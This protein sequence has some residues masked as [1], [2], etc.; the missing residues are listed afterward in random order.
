MWTSGLANLA[1]ILKF[2]PRLIRW[3]ELITVLRGKFVSTCELETEFYIDVPNGPRQKLWSRE[4]VTLIIWG[5]VQ[6]SKVKTGEE[7]SVDRFFE[8]NWNGPHLI[9]GFT[10]ACVWPSWGIRIL[11]DQLAPAI[12]VVKMMGLRPQLPKKR[13]YWER[14]EMEIET[15]QR[16]DLKVKIRLN[17]PILIDGG[18]HPTPWLR[19]WKFL[20]T[21]R[22]IHFDRNPHQVLSCVSACE[23]H[24]GREIE[25]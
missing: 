15:F 20:T 5:S 17:L 16:L 6:I 14:G 11:F 23:I 10:W 25:A 18:R 8:E 24:S 4:G 3:G 2:C 22:L 19:P 13:S 1:G 12:L 21:R 7:S 9:Q